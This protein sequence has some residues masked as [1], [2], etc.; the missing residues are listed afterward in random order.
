[1]KYAEPGIIFIDE[2]NR[3]NHM[4]S[5]MGP[6]FACNPCGEQQLHFNN[7]C[8]LGSIDVAKFS[9]G[10]EIEW[11]R[12]A[13]AVHL[14]TRFLDNVVDAGHFPLAELDDVVKRTRPV[15]LGIMGVA[16][17]CLKLGI[18]YGS[19]E[20]LELMEKAMAF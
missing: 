10:K 13:R 2:V 20:S 1:H 11:D 19:G 17:L 15:G 16:D 6:I 4:M 12:L 3:H 8:N 18:T 9:D 7:S 5:S 14:S